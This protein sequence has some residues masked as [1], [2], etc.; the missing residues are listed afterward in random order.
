MAAIPKI[1]FNLMSNHGKKMI[2][3]TPHHIRQIKTN[4]KPGKLA[5]IKLRD[6]IATTNIKSEQKWEKNLEI[7]TEDNFWWDVYKTQV[8]CTKE[9]NL[10]NF[11]YKLLT[12]IIPTNKFLYKCKLSDT[13][14][15]A[16][17]GIYTETIE[18]LF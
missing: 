11:Q 1:W 18:H 2:D 14:L 16:F 4:A 10:R 15:C 5:Y 17:C 12:R 9:T 6:L 7:E 13:S 8:K 3:P